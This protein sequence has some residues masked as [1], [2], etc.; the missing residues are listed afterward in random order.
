[1]LR[2]SLKEVSC[3][4]THTHTHTNTH[5]HGHTHTYTLVFSGYINFM[6]VLLTKIINMKE[7]FK[8]FT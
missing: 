8:N 5:T 4:H 3:T 2:C 1:M 7:N 6:S